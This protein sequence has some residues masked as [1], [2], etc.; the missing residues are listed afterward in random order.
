MAPR[1]PDI[2]VRLSSDDGNAFAVM[3][4]VRQALERHGVEPAEIKSFIAEA[5]AGDYNR[6]LTTCMRWVNIA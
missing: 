4:R 6:L 5:T 1:Y 3:G 2:E